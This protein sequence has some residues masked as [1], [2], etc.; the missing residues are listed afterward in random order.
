M[1]KLDYNYNFWNNIKVGVNWDIFEYS[2]ANKTQTLDMLD[3]VNFALQK[4]N[5]VIWINWS[6]HSNIIKTIDTNDFPKDSPIL[7]EWWIDWLIIKSLNSTKEKISIILWVADCWAINFTDKTWNNIGLVHAWYVWTAKWIVWNIFKQLE[8]INNFSEYKFYIAPMAWKNFELNKDFF[9]KLY[10]NLFNEYNFKFKDYI[11][12][13]YKKDWIKKIHINL[14][15]IINDILIHHW[16]KQENIVFSEIETNS[17]N[18]PWPSYRLNKTNK[19][20]WV[21]LE[22]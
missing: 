8:N 15:K 2:F 1:K 4:V 6:Q 13:E 11:F 21:F 17:K 16:V 9:E 18:N 19:R 3:L 12:K 7:L 22:N 14:R 10:K 5:K 20:I